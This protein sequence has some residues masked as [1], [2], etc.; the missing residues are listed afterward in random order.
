MTVIAAE[1]V[2]PMES[3]AETVRVF[4]PFIRVMPVAVNVLFDIVALIP[5]TLTIDVTSSTV[6]VTVTV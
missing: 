4:A 3:V 6:P 2:L 1:L 5:F